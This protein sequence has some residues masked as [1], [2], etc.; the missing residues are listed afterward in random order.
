MSDI[1]EIAAILT[2]LFL[3]VGVAG[4]VGL[5]MIS[6]VFNELVLPIIDKLRT[7]TALLAAL[8]FITAILSFMLRGSALTGEAYGMIDPEILGLMWQTPVGD[9]LAYR[10]AGSALIIIGL[11]TPHVGQWIALIGGLITL[12]SFAQIGH[13]PEL[14]APGVRLLL[15][16]HLLGIAFWIGVLGPLRALSR[17]LE[18]IASAATLGHRFGQAAAVIVPMLILAGLLL[19]WLLLGDL[20]ALVTTGYGQTLLIKLVLVGAVLALAAVN[21]FR[22]VPAMQSGDSKAAR[23]LARSIEIEAMVILLVLAV[24]ATL[25][26]VLTPQN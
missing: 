16:L 13:V 7:R 14:K 24:T 23:H 4:S 12:W 17:R 18:H 1:W 9:V 2:K 19:A 15:F 21:K 25:T 22:F 26:S 10:V 3:Y 6:A 8:A 5:V 20:R 11:F